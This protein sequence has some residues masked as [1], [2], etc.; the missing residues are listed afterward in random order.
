MG[1][2]VKLQAP[3]LLTEDENMTTPQFMACTVILGALIATSELPRMVMDKL[4]GKGRG[5]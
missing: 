1:G 2:G 3:P 5:R 4:T